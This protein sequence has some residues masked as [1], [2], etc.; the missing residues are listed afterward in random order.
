MI[1]QHR[2]PDG[3]FNDS[4]SHLSILRIHKKP[5]VNLPVFGIWFPI[6][7]RLVEEQGVSDGN[8]VWNSS[9][10]V[11]DYEDITN[12]AGRAVRTHQDPSC[13]H[14]VDLM[15]IIFIS[16]WL[17][18]DR[19]HCFLHWCVPWGRTS[20]P[21]CFDSEFMLYAQNAFSLYSKKTTSPVGGFLAL[22]FLVSVRI[23]NVFWSLCLLALPPISLRI[24]ILQFGAFLRRW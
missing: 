20:P 5:I 23:S 21:V 16:S 11:P 6:P 7:M 9:N 18:V 12:R 3:L 10:N 22:G 15:R 19:A 8:Y 2:F 24:F 13:T 1:L 17:V 4:L 14:F